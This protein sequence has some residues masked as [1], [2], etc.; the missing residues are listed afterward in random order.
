MVFLIGDFQGYSL[1]HSSNHPNSD[2]TYKVLTVLSSEDAKIDTQRWEGSCEFNHV[3][4]H[5]GSSTGVAG[6]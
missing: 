1:C 4:Y 5:V 3:L 6:T 2:T